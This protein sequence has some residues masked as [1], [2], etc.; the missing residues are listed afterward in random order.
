M[1]KC[2]FFW[3]GYHS[4][5]QP[6]YTRYYI[7]EGNNIAINQNLDL[8]YSKHI[9]LGYSHQLNKNFGIKAEAYY[10]DLTGIPIEID[11][12]TFLIS[13]GFARVFKCIK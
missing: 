11:S 13:S 12:S 7:P 4:Q 10:Q 6:L 2:T 9:V 3:H 1:I 5:T 8:T